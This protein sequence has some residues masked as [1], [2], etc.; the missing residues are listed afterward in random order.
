MLRYNSETINT[1]QQF[2]LYVYYLKTRFLLRSLYIP[3]ETLRKY[4]ESVVS[5][6]LRV[7]NLIKNTEYTD[8][9]LNQVFYK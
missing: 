6:K 5:R 4:L 3:Y 7:A 1:F 2:D 8:R 9:D